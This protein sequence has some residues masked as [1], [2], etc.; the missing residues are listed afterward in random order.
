MVINMLYKSFCESDTRAVAELLAKQSKPK[1]IFCLNGDLGA[2]KTFFVQSF[3]R[4]L[5]IT[6]NIS[7]P[8]F[9]IINEYHGKEIN[10]YHFDVYRI[11]SLEEL[12]YTN[13]Q[14]Y[15]YGDS[16]CL[17]EWAD[18]IKDIIPKSATQIY[19]Y[20]NLDISPDYR[21]IKLI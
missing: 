7:S 6:E 18:I 8:T 10:L 14:D 2:G 12:E 19:F 21:L 5:G 11:S 15:F 3:A 17:I 16:I 20:K 4:V 1:D 13:Y 9:T